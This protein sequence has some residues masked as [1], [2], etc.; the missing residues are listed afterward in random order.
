MTT[1]ITL[2]I[3]QA[4]ADQI[5]V[6]VGSKENAEATLYVGVQGPPGAGLDVDKQLLE[7]TL[8]A[9]KVLTDKSTPAVHEHDIISEESLNRQKKV[10]DEKLAAVSTLADVLVKQLTK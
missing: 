5:T 7:K 10:L 8:A 3:G 6:A 1:P 4:A 2:V 9:M